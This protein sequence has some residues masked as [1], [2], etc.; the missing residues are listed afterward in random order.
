MKEIK[1]DIVRPQGIEDVWL[2]VQS[3]TFPSVVVGCVYRHPKAHVETFAYI[4]DVF[5]LVCLKNKPL[6]ILGDFNDDLSC[7]YK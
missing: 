5:T 6:Y 2:S 1:F 3:C 7:Q 4:S